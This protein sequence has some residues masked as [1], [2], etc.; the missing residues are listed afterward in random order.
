[1]PN[2]RN[3]CWCFAPRRASMAFFASRPVREGTFCRYS[4]KYLVRHTTSSEHERVS[5]YLSA[6]RPAVPVRRVAGGSPGDLSAMRSEVLAADTASRDTK[7]PKTIQTTT[8]RNCPH[9]ERIQL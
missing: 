1:M 4:V 6:L 3:C 9:V 5:F 2:S 7:T 8:L